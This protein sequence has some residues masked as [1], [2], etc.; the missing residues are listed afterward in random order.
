MWENGSM[1]FRRLMLMIL[2]VLFRMEQRS[3]AAST[4]YVYCAR[5][6]NCGNNVLYASAFGSYGFV[7]A[8]GIADGGIMTSKCRQLYGNSAVVCFSSEASTR[9]KSG[10]SSMVCGTTTKK[11]EINIL[12]SCNVAITDGAGYLGSGHICDVDFDLSCPSDFECDDGYYLQSGVCTPLN[13]CSGYSGT[14]FD[15]DQ[16]IL[17]TDGLCKKFKCKDSNKGFENLYT[18]KCINCENGVAADGMCKTTSNTNGQISSDDSVGC[19]V[20]VKRGPNEKGGC[21]ECETGDIYNSITH[22]CD[23]AKKIEKG[24]LLYG[25][26]KTSGGKK[27][28]NEWCWAKTNSD[29]YKKCV[30]EITE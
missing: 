25:K 24:H 30:H 17:Y 15:V 8:A 19:T 20:G 6:G 23:T 13:L 5:G 22:K 21:I 7:S 3:W 27:F 9:I 12:T 26:T 11:T 29:E 16:Y 18:K 14:L 2:A 10:A 28:D 1:F 4:Y